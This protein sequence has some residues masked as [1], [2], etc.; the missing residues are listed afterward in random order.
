[1]PSGTFTSISAGGP[2]T[3]GLRADGTMVGWG[4]DYYG[5]A[6][7]QPGVFSQV[8]SGA[9][10]SA[11]LKPDGTITAWGYTHFG[12]SNPPPGQYTYVASTRDWS[13]AIAVP[14][15]AACVSI[16]MLALTFL[17]RR[18]GHRTQCPAR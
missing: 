14:E 6:T 11:A 15:P 3:L 5:E 13:L 9:Y 17:R 2:H 1:M 4:K 16:G 12:E 7:A 18:R 8:A 10:H